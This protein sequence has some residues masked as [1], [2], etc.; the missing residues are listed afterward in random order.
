MEVQEEQ[1]HH[2]S[3]V[4]KFVLIKVLLDVCLLRLYCLTCLHY[5]ERPYHSDST[6]SRLLSEVKHCRARLVS[7]TVGDHVGIP[8]VVL[9]L[10]FAIFAFDA[11]IAIHHH[12]TLFTTSLLVYEEEL[13]SS[14][15]LYLKLFN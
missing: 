5:Q 15:L 11:L 4:L 14:F 7:T 9:F 10:L 12:V 1:V 6:A 8:G 3:F 2:G 13:R